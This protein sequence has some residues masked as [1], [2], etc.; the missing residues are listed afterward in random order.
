MTQ[1]TTPDNRLQ[2]ALDAGVRPFVLDP[3]ETV[4]INLND[5]E[6]ADPEAEDIEDMYGP[7]AIS[8]GAFSPARENSPKMDHSR[9][10][11]RQQE[12]TKQQEIAKLKMLIAEKEMLRK[13]KVE[14]QQQ[15][16]QQQQQQQQQPI[17][18]RPWTSLHHH[19]Y[20]QQQ[21]HQQQ[22]VMIYNN[23]LMQ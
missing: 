15:H 5:L 7:F 14:K 17:Q 21:Q 16:E 22:P 6:E 23:R 8:N 11:A 20:H 1:A 3:Q 12:L 19:R 4:V 18:R 10:T 9:I 2:A 13:Q